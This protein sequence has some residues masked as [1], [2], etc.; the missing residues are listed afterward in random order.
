MPRSSSDLIPESREKLNRVTFSFSSDSG[1]HYLYDDVTGG[2]FPWNDLRELVLDLV[3]SDTYEK[4]QESLAMQYGQ[5]DVQAEYRFINR[6]R[7]N[8]GAFARSC[9]E[10]REPACPTIE[11]LE[12]HIRNSSFE[13]L[14]IVTED[15]NLRCK[16][17][18]YSDAYPLNRQR[19]GRKMDFG[20]A[21]QAVDWY[22]NL[23]KPQ[24]VRNPRKRFGL[25]LYGGEALMNM[26][27]VKQVLEYVR[28]AYPGCFLTLMTTNGTLL[29]EKFVRTLVEHEVLLAISID[30]PAEEHDR[31]RVNARNRGTF[32]Q[33]VANLRRI[34]NNYPVYWATK[35]TSVS[36]YDWGTDLEAVEQFFSDHEDIIPRS[37]FVNQ[38]GFCNT[39]WYDQYS[40]ANRD[41]ML[42]SL[43]RLREKYKRAKIADLPTNH[44][45]RS[46]VGLPI[47]MALLRRRIGDERSRLLPFSGSCIPGDKLAIHVDGTIDMCERVN[48]TYPIGHLNSGI[49]YER[50]RKIID[51]YHQKVLGGCS[52]CPATK[53]CSVCFSL[54]EANADFVEVP[55][56]CAATVT[57][58]QQ[59]LGDYISI[60]EANPKADFFFDTDTSHLEE[61]LL[62]VY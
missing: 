40:V 54:A 25:S 48:G 24:F 42:S 7:K 55:W 3:L 29:T 52:R 6:L 39:T 57:N 33:I 51:R 23:V 14:L 36:V 47:A 8:Y 62:L 21:K 43:E 27:V 12:K 26:P 58:A 44:Y 15:C 2:I 37:V 45:M 5:D 22:I 49:D 32:E 18:V 35:L 53:L 56:H 31:L 20:T 10:A 30:G 46:L 34:K 41:S 11:H 60:L 28:D 16:Y 17:C 9:S 38:I 19:T 61:R 1:R 50:V 4:N 13:L 59:S